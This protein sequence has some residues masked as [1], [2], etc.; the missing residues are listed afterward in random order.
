MVFDKYFS[1]PAAL[2][3]Q[4]SAPLAEERERFLTHLEATGTGRSAIRIAATLRG[5]RRVE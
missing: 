3:R 5:I 1:L 2:A 4:R